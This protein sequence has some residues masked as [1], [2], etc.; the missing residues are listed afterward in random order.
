VSM[1]NPVEPRTSL[2]HIPLRRPRFTTSEIIILNELMNKSPEPVT[3]SRLK[4]LLQ[5]HSSRLY[6]I[7]E[8]AIG[9]HMSHLRAKLGEQSRHHTLI[10]SVHVERRDGTVE[11]AY[12]YRNPEDA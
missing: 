9:Q 5:S 2:D 7:Y 10:V 4:R 1:I 6:P 8:T 12:M 3:I 11:L